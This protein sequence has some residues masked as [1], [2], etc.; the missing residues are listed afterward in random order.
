MINLLVDESLKG[1]T[2]FI[3]K[4]AINKMKAVQ[5]CVATKEFEYSKD[6]LVLCEV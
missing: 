1:S 5:P 3:W 2:A 4:K 6:E